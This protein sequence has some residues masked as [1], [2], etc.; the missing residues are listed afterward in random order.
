MISTANPAAADSPSFPR[1][2]GRG[3]SLD[4]FEVERSLK[5]EVGLAGGEE[6]G[7]GVR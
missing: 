1:R 3:R 7:R 5:E 4:S 2:R 6:G